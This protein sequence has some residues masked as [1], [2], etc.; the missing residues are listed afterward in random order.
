MEDK[1]GCRTRRLALAALVSIALLLGAQPAPAGAKQH[2]ARRGAAIAMETE[3]LDGAGNNLAHPGW[4]EAGSA[5]ARLAPARYTDGIGAMEGGPN[6]RY[7]S[8][9]IFNSLGVNLYSER[10]LSQWAWAW[11]QFVDHTIG[12]AE[13][14]EEEA[15]ISFDATDPLESFSDTLGAIPFT[16]SAVLTGTGTSPANPREQINTVG[17]YID[18]SA[19]YGASAKRLEWLRTGPDNGKPG[20]SGAELLLAHGYLPTAAARG[21]AATAPSMI[22]EGALEATPQSAV[23]A[24]DVRANENAELTAVTTLFAREHDRIA[25][26]LPS[27]LTAEERFQIARRVVAAEEQYITYTEFLP[28]LGVTLSPYH[29]YDPGVNT[30]LSDEFATIGFR[31]HSMVNSS[32]ELAPAHYSGKKVAAMQ[33]LGLQVVLVSKRPKQ[34]QVTIPQGAAFFDPAVVPAAGLGQVLEG[35][36]LD[37]AV[38]NDEQVGDAL[39]SVMFG[40]PGP[41]TEPAACFG[42]PVPAG[43]FSVVEDLAA[44]DIQRSRDNGMPTY[45]ELRE[46]L[47][48]PPQSTFAQV[49]GEASED[50]PTGDPLVPATDAIDDPHILDFTSLKNLAGEP[51]AP[52]S[53][54]RAVY[55]TRRTTLAARLKA[56]YGSVGNLDA[57]VGMVSEPHL[58]GSDL[59]EL[60]AALWRRQFEALR[61]GDRFFYL[62]DP[63][64]EAIEREYGITYKRSLSDL[65][66]LDAGVPAVRLGPEMFTAPEPAH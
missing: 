62:N 25:A 33:A 34:M 29:G 48:L 15:P 35:L 13:P 52:G 11:G 38:K 44:V 39:R 28:A 2:A 12:R 17:S 9:R 57:Y 23:V 40:I 60:Q 41:G 56:I 43:C 7:V 3:S 46:A 8:N 59:G 58:P 53:P 61:D 4:G 54:E 36:W 37:P 27:T 26:A 20:T 19:I 21:N 47:G 49:T 55:A 65:I 30:D 14:G 5:Y 32:L 24:G 66:T 64:L 42:E 63:A 50:F 22:T 1:R 10:N 31:L 45:D 16:R 18:G 51:I 6:P